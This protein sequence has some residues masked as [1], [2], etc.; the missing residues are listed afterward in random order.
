M[1]IVGNGQN[2]VSI[3][4][5]AA[6]RQKSHIVSLYSITDKNLERLRRGKAGDRIG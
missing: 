2:Y 1:T 3:L 4:K 6:S 5:T